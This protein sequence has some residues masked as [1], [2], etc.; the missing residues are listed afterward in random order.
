MSIKKP[1]SVKGGI[2][3]IF[4]LIIYYLSPAR[5]DPLLSASLHLNIGTRKLLVGRVSSNREPFGTCL[6]TTTVGRSSSL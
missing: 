5:L 1:G 4:L 6:R 2:P 3:D